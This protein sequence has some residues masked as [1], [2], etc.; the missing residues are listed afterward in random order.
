MAT[1]NT[2]SALALEEALRRK[3]RMSLW[4]EPFYILVT[5]K[6]LASFGLAILVLMV[7]T[8]VFADIIAPYSPTKQDVDIA[9]SAP[10][11]QHLLGT[12]Q[13]G[14]DV[15]SRLMLGARTS[16]YV[17]VGVVLFGTTAATLLGS[18]SAFVGGKYDLIYQRLVDA[19][20]AIPSLILL[21]TIISVLGPGLLKIILALSIRQSI[22]QSRVPRSAVLGIMGNQY[23]EAAR[24][25]G[26]SPVR[27][28]FRY[29]LPNIM[30]PVTIIA[31]L[32][33]GT[34]ILSEATLSFLGWGVPPPMPTWGGMLSDEARRFM[35]EAPWLAIFPG[36]ALSMAVYGINMFGDGVR[37]VLDP[38]QRG[39]H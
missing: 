3:K 32:T 39:A 14:R 36:L 19:F 25:V 37:D 33:L 26:A 16:L 29:I 18:I 13:L 11:F 6:Y 38:R 22:S 20:L 2:A 9:L 7:L 24:A 34:A 4:V 10:S 28:L 21:L 5:R 15:L 8:A 17:G 31:S 30:A 27:I 12:D 35:V 1:Q 23:F